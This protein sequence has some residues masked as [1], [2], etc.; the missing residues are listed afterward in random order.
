MRQSAAA[1]SGVSIQGVGGDLAR[2]AL[3]CQ[4][5]TGGRGHDATWA[6]GGMAASHSP[7]DRSAEETVG[8]LH[9]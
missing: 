2:G 4:R 1:A 9:A 7:K 6:C 5:L 3:S 8:C